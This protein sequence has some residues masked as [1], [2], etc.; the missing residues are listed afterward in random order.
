MLLSVLHTALVQQD[1]TTLAWAMNNASS[2]DEKEILPLVK[3][4]MSFGA[5]CDTPQQVLEGKT[6]LQMA[7]H[8]KYTK[9]AYAMRCPPPAAL[10]IDPTQLVTEDTDEDCSIDSSSPVGRYKIAD[11]LSSHTLLQVAFLMHGVIPS[12][13]FW[14]SSRGAAC[15]SLCKPSLSSKHSMA[16]FGWADSVV[17]NLKVTV[18]LSHADHR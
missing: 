11:C 2:S 14:T 1:S 12:L 16:V 3:V 6:C 17:R 9:C 18:I 10:R 7:D 5:R 8:K 15:F 13:S 4:L